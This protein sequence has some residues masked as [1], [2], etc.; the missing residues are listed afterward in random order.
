MQDKNYILLVTSTY[1]SGD[2]PNSGVKLLKL[3][4]SPG[5]VDSRRLSHVTFSV[6][7]LGSTAYPRFC[8]AA[9]QFYEGFIKC[10]AKPL[11]DELVRV[12]EMTHPEAT[13]NRWTGMVLGV[14]EER[15][16]LSFAA[17]G[18]LGGH[19]LKGPFPNSTY[20]PPQP[21]FSVNSL[22]NEGFEIVK[23]PI[24]GIATVVVASKRMTEKNAAVVHLEIIIPREWARNKLVSAGDEVMIAA[25]NEAIDVKRIGAAIGL[26]G[27]ALDEM[28]S[29]QSIDPTVLIES[30][31]FETPL[32]LRNILTHYLAINDV[33]S[34]DNIRTLAYYSPSDEGLAAASASFEA[35]EKMIYKRNMKWKDAFHHFPSLYGKITATHLVS[36]IPLIRHRYYS[37]ASAPKTIQYSEK[38]LTK[39]VVYDKG[40]QEPDAELKRVE[41]GRMSLYIPTS[42]TLI[43]DE[44][45]L[46]T[47]LYLLYPLHPTFLILS[48]LLQRMKLGDTYTPQPGDLKFDLVVSTHQFLNHAKEHEKGFCSNWLY[49]RQKNDV[50]YL[51][52]VMMPNF[53][54]P[55]D[56]QT[57]VVLIGAGA[58]IAP[59][60]AFWQERA[61]R[62]KA[63]TSFEKPGAHLYL[64]Y[65]ALLIHPLYT[66]YTP[67]LHLYTPLCTPYTPLYTPLLTISTISIISTISTISTISINYFT[68]VY[69]TITRTTI[70]V[71]PSPALPTPFTAYFP[72]LIK[73]LC[74]AWRDRLA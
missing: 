72:P 47:P 30:Y 32:S 42:L 3:L 58:G 31:P 20:E 5:M 2:V 59:L 12:D 9:D 29:L 39:K 65:Y 71:I 36:M 46:C 38:T 4:Q 7:G 54:L 69:H 15:K 70:G 10:G 18:F 53:R 73:L 6:L 28:V 34:Y 25:T 66:S 21:L 14:F 19:K 17:V 45:S 13:L 44:L 63:I 52:T 22:K 64:P 41:V 50:I 33:L 60:R 27:D 23:K 68:T 61:R 24:N 57:P 8:A 35:Y 11:F 67:P 16:I 37:I 62:L 49:N 43:H 51:N 26:I 74:I 56:I 55:Y 40:E 48:P 1:G